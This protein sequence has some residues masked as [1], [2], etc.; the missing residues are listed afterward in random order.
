VP[1]EAD[2]RQCRNCYANPFAMSKLA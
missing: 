1:Y 2:G